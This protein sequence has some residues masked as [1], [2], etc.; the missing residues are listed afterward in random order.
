MQ[1]YFFK[2]CVIV[3][4]PVFLFPP[5]PAHCAESCV[6][7]QCMAPNTCQCEPGWGG[8]NCSSG[9]SSSCCCL[10]AVISLCVRLWFSVKAL[11]I[12]KRKNRLWCRLTDYCTVPNQHQQSDTPQ[13]QNI[14]LTLIAVCL[15]GFKHGRGR[16][17]LCLCQFMM[18][19][20]VM[21]VILLLLKLLWAGMSYQHETW[22]NNWKLC[23]PRSMS[24]ICEMVAL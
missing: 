2:V 5:Y 19:V 16:T 18:M 1:I 14:L 20:M 7:G 17:L 23:F 24:P 13:E 8:S 6:H 10:W 4:I 12:H 3:L 9:K 22:P 11:L 21:M 15:L